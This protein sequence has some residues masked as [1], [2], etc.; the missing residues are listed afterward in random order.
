MDDT[1]PHLRDPDAFLKLIYLLES[2]HGKLEWGAFASVY[3]VW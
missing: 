2:A 3:D 1:A